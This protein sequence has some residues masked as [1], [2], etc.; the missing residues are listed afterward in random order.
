[1]LRKF[2]AV[3]EELEAKLLIVGDSGVGEG[4]EDEGVAFVG[5]ENADGGENVG[6]E[7]AKLRGGDVEGVGEVGNEVRVREDL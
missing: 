7:G 3:D 1:V 2:D 4:G 6:D 5:R